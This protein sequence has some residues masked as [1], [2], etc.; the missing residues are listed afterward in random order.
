MAEREV[1]ALEDSPEAELLL[2]GICLDV[3]FGAQPSTIPPTPCLVLV[4][5]NPAEPCT[6]VCGHTYCY[7]CLHRLGFDA[8]QVLRSVIGR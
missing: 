2:C 5:L 1:E 3:F 6:L 4:P 8:F 7:D